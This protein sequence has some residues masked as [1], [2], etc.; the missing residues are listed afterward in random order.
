MKHYDWQQSIRAAAMMCESALWSV[1]AAECIGDK[2]A[3][4]RMQQRAEAEALY[5]FEVARDNA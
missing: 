1:R 2:S 5:A 4:E 3:A